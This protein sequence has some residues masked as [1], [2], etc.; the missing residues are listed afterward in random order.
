MLR[1]LKTALPLLLLLAAPLLLRTRE[2]KVQAAA[3][4]ALTIFS[5]HSESVKYEMDVAFARHYRKATGRSVNVEWLNVGGTSD[6]VRY[7]DERYTT[8]FRRQWEAAGHA[9]T[10]AVA[11]GFKD[12][13]ATDPEAAAARAAFLASDVGIGV[14]VFFGGGTFDQQ[15][16]ADCGYAVP[17]DLAAVVPGYFRTVPANFSGE[18]LRDPGERF[19]GACLSSF[20]VCYNPARVRELGMEHPQQWADLALPGYRG[21]VIVG[22]PTKSGS[23]NKCFE[24]ILQQAMHEAPDPGAGWEVGFARLLAIL[25]NSRQ[26][27]DSAGAVTREVAA[28]NAAAGMAI[29]FY[30]L[31]EAEWSAWQSGGEPRIAYVLPKNGSA[32]TADPVQML[33]GAPNREAARAFIAFVLSPEG[34]KLWNYRPGEPGGPEKHALRRQPILPAM[35]GPEHRPHMADPGYNPYTDAKGFEYK[36]EYTGR[37]F[38]LLRVLVKCAMLDVHDELRAAWGAIC[39][40]GGPEKCPAAWA[41]FSRAPVIYA[42]APALAART[43]GNGAEALAA[44]RELTLAAQGRFARAA[45]LARD[46]K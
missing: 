26:V 21:A 17:A 42:E 46:G 38:N 33:R 23:I 40:A 11:S 13:G 32:V 20:G 37:Y 35:Y 10:P 3:H 1:I 6:I 36:P 12:P 18:T 4:E 45:A 5:P 22:D 41:E 30:A 9:W 15:R 25:G 8:L 16:L 34:Q 31:S 14:D 39:D 27:T 7:I 24:M 43:R 44:R 19:Y 2:A 28:G 29:D